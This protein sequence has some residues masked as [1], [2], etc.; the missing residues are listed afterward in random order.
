[1]WPVSPG[2]DPA[3]DRSDPSGLTFTLSICDT[4][5]PGGQWPLVHRRPLCQHPPGPYPS[6][7]CP[8]GAICHCHQQTNSPSSQRQESGAAV[9]M[10]PEIQSLLSAGWFGCG[11][12]EP[13]SGRSG[14]KKGGPSSVV[15]ISLISPS[16]RCKK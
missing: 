7:A 3:R 12:W 6:T 9:S 16:Q 11:R 5:G 10:S 4:A 1:M 8:D 2:E 15:G 14:S 13:G